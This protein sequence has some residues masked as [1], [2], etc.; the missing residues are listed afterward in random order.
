MLKFVTRGLGQ[1][2][3]FVLPDLGDMNFPEMLILSVDQ[4]NSGITKWTVCT[5]A[6]FTNSK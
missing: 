1:N 5:R 2:D 4:R 6:G 3:H